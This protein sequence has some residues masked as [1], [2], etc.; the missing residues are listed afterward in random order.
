[1]FCAYPKGGIASKQE[2]AHNKICHRAVCVDA[3]VL[4][5]SSLRQNLR[6]LRI[7][8]EKAITRFEPPVIDCF[9][10]CFDSNPCVCRL[11]KRQ[12]WA[13]KLF[14]VGRCPSQF[15]TNPCS[16]DSHRS[17]CS[18]LISTCPS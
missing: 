1:M 11:I 10:D 6:R 7:T 8:V 14:D 18:R 15:Q 16:G 5:L 9:R 13:A 2:T 4:T 3:P 17:V 12:R